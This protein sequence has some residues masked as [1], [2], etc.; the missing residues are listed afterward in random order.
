MN[1]D[2]DTGCSWIQSITKITEILR[3]HGKE[4]LV[5]NK[6]YHSGLCQAASTD[7]IL[8]RKVRSYATPRP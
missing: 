6:S 2:K 4:A 5:R 7:L 8:Q 3:T 1:F